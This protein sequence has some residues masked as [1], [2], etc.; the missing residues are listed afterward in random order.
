[1]SISHSLGS[2]Y[3]SKKVHASLVNH[4]FQHNPKYLSGLLTSLSSIQ[5]RIF[6]A[7]FESQ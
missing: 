1:M 7:F 2:T 6:L 3:E 5:L 4:N